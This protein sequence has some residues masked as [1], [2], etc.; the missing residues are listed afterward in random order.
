MTL[1]E[2]TYKGVTFRLWTHP[3]QPDCLH[4]GAHG[5]TEALGW[6]AYRQMQ[7]R[8]DDVF[9]GGPPGHLWRAERLA[10]DPL[11]EDA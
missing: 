3:E 5:K 11:W 8:F 6:K 10:A 7:P 2:W 4:L 1:A 9:H